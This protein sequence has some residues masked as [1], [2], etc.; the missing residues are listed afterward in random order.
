MGRPP[1]RLVY[2]DIFPLAFYFFTLH[3]RLLP[4][5]ALLPFGC[6]AFLFLLLWQYAQIVFFFLFI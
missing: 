5:K 6:N 2:K 3:F 1:G 4:Q